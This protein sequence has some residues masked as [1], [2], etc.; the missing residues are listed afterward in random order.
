MVSS[1]H[2]CRCH[3]YQNFDPAS[4][5]NIE[6]DSLML[7]FQVGRF[8]Q[9]Q[10]DISKIRKKHASSSNLKLRL[11][12]WKWMDGIRSVPFG[13]SCPFSASPKEMGHSCQWL[14]EDSVLTTAG[15]GDNFWHLHLQPLKRIYLKERYEFHF[16]FIYRFDCFSL[17]KSGQHVTCPCWR[18]NNTLILIFSILILCIY[19]YIYYH[20]HGDHLKYTEN[21]QTIR[22][23]TQFRI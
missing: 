23:V 18:W 14:A 19:I 7:S 20:S 16:G 2:L 13:V 17:W 22:V 6:V 10:C 3:I 8:I 9:N 11:C 15:D 12:T 21:T 5:R 1:A 4:F